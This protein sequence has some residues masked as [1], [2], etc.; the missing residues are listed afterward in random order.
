MFQTKVVEKIKTHILC[1]VTFF[2]NC[3]IYEIMW[4]N[5][6]ERGR[7][8]MTIWHMC[9]ACWIPKATNTHSDYIILTAFPPQQWLDKCAMALCYIYIACIVYCHHLKCRNLSHNHMTSIHDCY[10]CYCCC[11]CGGDGG[12]WRFFDGWCCCWCKNNMDS[13]LRHQ[14]NMQ[15]LP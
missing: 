1:S 14:L 4:K 15:T 8:Q 5:I 9:I 7:P 2:E 11:H 12:L 10:C 13:E 6:V 3:A